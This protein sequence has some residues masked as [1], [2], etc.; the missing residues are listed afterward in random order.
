MGRSCGSFRFFVWSHVY[1]CLDEINFYPQLGSMRFRPP[2]SQLWNA[3]C[4]REF[5]SRVH[6][7][8]QDL[9]G[10]NQKVSWFIEIF[11]LPTFSQET[12]LKRNVSHVVSSLLACLA[13]RCKYTCIFSSIKFHF[14][15]LFFFFFSKITKV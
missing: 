13:E 15:I 5:C 6:T 14:V 3:C 2:S 4:V 12:L 7:T 10:P 8:S 1:G 9:Q 11:I